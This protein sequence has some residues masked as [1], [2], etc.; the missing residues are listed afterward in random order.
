[1][2]LFISQNKDTFLENFVKQF[3]KETGIKTKLVLGEEIFSNSS[4]SIKYENNKFNSKIKNFDFDKIKLCFINSTLFCFE[5]YFAFENN[6][7]REYA[8]Q[9][10]NASLLCLFSTCSSTKFINPYKKI[11]PL[12]NEFECL[13]LFQKYKL[14]TCEMHLTNNSQDFLDIYSIY[15][16]NMIVKTPVLGYD[17]S[18]NVD[19]VTLKKLNKLYLSPYLLQKPQNGNA[20]NICIIGKEIL[21]YDINNNKQIIISKGI[22][23]KLKKIKKEL[24]LSIVTFYAISKDDEFKFYSINQNP[25]FTEMQSLYKQDFERVLT[26]FLTKEYKH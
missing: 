15:N 7:D 23:E 18:K 8:I 3:Q 26:K 25:T 10:W 13:L 14:E 21:A 17:K 6:L 12:Q 2:I 11:N 1:M 24:N 19:K 9:E 20:I 16:H 5:N 4:I 22:I